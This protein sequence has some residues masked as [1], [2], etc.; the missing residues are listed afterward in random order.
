[1]IDH[2]QEENSL[3]HIHGSLKNKEVLKDKTTGM[4]SIKNEALKGCERRDAVL[5]KRTGKPEIHI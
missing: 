4:D 2:I 1:M 5:C 3:D